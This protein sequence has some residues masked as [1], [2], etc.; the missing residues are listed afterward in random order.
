[1]RRRTGPGI[2][3]LLLLTGTSTSGFS[4][5]GHDHGPNA[6]VWRDVDSL[7]E[8][9]ATFVSETEGVVRLLKLDGSRIAVPLLRLS[10]ADR[11]WVR[12]KT[13]EIRQL[14]GSAV[15]SVSASVACPPNTLLALTVT[16][17]LAG[18]GVALRRHVRGPIIPTVGLMLVVAATP[19][20]CGSQPGN[21]MASRHPQ[22]KHD[23]DELRKLFEAFKADGVTFRTD[24]DFFFVESNA[25]PKHPMMKG[26]KAWQQQVPLPQPYTGINAWRIPLK[27][28]VSDNPISAKTA[29][30]RG[31]I[32]LAVNGVPIFNALNNRGEDTFLAGE[33]DE[34]G[35]HCGR[36][37]DYHYHVAPVHLEK[38]VGIGKPIAYA[39]DGF[40]L[41]GYADGLGQNAQALDEFNG[42]F[43]TDG[44]Y[45]YYS[46]KTY[47]YVNGG[48][49][50]V[51]RVRGDQIDPQPRDAPV[52]PA[53]KPLRGAT[54]TGFTRDDGA[55]RI[56][57]TTRSA[58]CRLRLLTR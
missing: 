12:S 56:G 3:I 36:G 27:P 49:R 8:L 51:V 13:A 53:G 11:E 45:R 52:R 14:N 15:E 17:G 33:L 29:L 10:L 50:G 55:K 1:M 44:T 25:F 9:E 47:P 39:L 48:M 6:R 34:Y 46:S 18:L 58:R 54:I 23:E 21:V 22:P 7:F 30:Y 24:G 40:P 2:L 38:I 19:A 32:A 5:P 43:E 42:R 31:A 20:G 35:G 26:I 41:Y 16:V 57:S 4:H 28:V 37:D